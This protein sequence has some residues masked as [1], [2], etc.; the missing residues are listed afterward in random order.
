MLYDNNS[1]NNN[2]DNIDV[3]INDNNNNNNN[4]NNDNKYYLLCCYSHRLPLFVCIET[5]AESSR[6]FVLEKRNHRRVATTVSR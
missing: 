3:N 5:N 4:D 2:N 1:N 6:I